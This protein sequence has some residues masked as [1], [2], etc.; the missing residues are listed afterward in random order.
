MLE[1]YENKTSLNIHIGAIVKDLKVKLPPLA[2][3]YKP[4]QY[5]CKMKE[6]CEMFGVK[7][8]VG[9]LENNPGWWTRFG[10][11]QGPKFES[12]KFVLSGCRG[13]LNKRRVL[14]KNCND[15]IHLAICLDN[16]TKIPNDIRCGVG[17]WLA[18]APLVFNGYYISPYMTA[19]GCPKRKTSRFGCK[20][21]TCKK[22][23]SFYRS[24]IYTGYISIRQCCKT[25]NLFIPKD[26]IKLILRQIHVVPISSQHGYDVSPRI[27][28]FYPDKIKDCPVPENDMSIDQINLKWSENIKKY[29]SCE[30]LI[31]PN[32]FLFKCP[33]IRE[34]CKFSGKKKWGENCERCIDSDDICCR[35]NL[36][37]C[38]YDGKLCSNCLYYTG[39]FIKY[40]FPYF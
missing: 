32:L 29:S 15:R 6:I 34:E 28:Y 19:I 11:T 30:I 39:A 14:C 22:C 5:Y 26:L 31:N 35:Y 12:Y 7:E 13:A 23:I 20:E 1:Y 8:N 3:K 27:H 24:Q 36:K 37:E 10:E 2:Q 18:K 17:V 4:K 38:S 21:H 16:I 9:T 25:N 33:L 40:G